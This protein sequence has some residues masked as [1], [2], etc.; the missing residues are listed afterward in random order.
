MPS[1]TLQLLLRIHGGGKRPRI[2]V[3]INYS[4]QI[5]EA[6]ALWDL[7]GNIDKWDDTRWVSLL[8]RLT[9]EE[10]TDLMEN[11]KKLNSLTRSVKLL[12]NIK[13]FKVVK[14]L[15]DTVGII[16]AQCRSKM[17]EAFD[18]KW[19]DNATFRE[20]MTMVKGIKMGMIISSASTD[21]NA[22]VASLATSFPNL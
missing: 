20:A 7:I 15:E 13:E 21:V 17:A 19:G 5:T 1:A 16:L 11:T 18:A 2:N 22:T 8:H 9:M 10:L 12:D 14:T 4:E 6:K 3:E